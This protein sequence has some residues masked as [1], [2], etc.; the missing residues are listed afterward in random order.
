MN[1]VS[2]VENPFENRKGWASLGE[3]NF[4]TLGQPAS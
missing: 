2:P 1:I 3:I 4:Q